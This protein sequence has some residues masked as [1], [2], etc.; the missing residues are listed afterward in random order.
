MPQI[1]V[2]PAGGLDLHS[3]E[4]ISTAAATELSYP[5]GVRTTTGM[6]RVVLVWYSAN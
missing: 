3:F 6:M 1:E 5:L 4:P 2:K